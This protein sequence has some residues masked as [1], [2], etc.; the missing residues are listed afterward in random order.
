MKQ[1][2]FG[3]LEQAILNRPRHRVGMPQP[4]RR[5]SAD[6]SVLGSALESAAAHNRKEI[7]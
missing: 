4:Y 5:F 7:T 2:L 1:M 3:P 6:A